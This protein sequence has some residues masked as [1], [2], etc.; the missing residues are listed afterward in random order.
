[1]SDIDDASTAALRLLNMSRRRSR[2]R[3]LMC[4]ST[5]SAPGSRTSSMSWRCRSGRSGGCWFRRGGR[6][7]RSGGGSI[8]TTCARSWAW[9]SASSTCRWR[10]PGWACA[11]RWTRCS[12][13]P[14]GRWP[15]S[16]TSSP[17]IRD[18]VYHNQK[19][20]S[21]LYGLLIRETFQRPV[22]RGFL[23][24]LRSKHKV[25]PIEFTRGRLHR[26]R[27]GAARNPG[28]HP[29]PAA[30]PRNL[31]EGPLPRLLLPKYLHPVERL[32]RK[33]LYEKTD[34][35]ELKL[36]AQLAWTA[37]SSPIRGPLAR[38]DPM[39]LTRNSR[40]WYSLGDS[41]RPTTVIHQN[42]D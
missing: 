41:G 15:L 19:M 32:R 37:T 11:A 13:W 26:G 35:D 18:Q 7:T 20:Q 14:T 30:S 21:V 25:V 29:E 3:S 31:L 4:W 8:P 23:C 28:S 17:S 42:K 38:L 12:R 22:H 9:F 27:S 1:M 6:R 10:R 40:P 34:Y 16:T 2:L 39:R 33:C 24:Y 5:S 36:R